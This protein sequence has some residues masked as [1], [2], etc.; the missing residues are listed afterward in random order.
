MN[1]FEMVSKFFTKPNNQSQSK[2]DRRKP[3]EDLVPFSPQASHNL[4]VSPDI[5]ST[6]QLESY[7][8]WIYVAVT[9]LA[10]SV[11]EIELKLFESKGDNEPEEVKTH[12]AIDVLQDVNQFMTFYDLVELYQ[13]YMELSGEAFWWLVKSDSGE[14]LQIYPY[15]RPDRMIVVSDSKEFIKGYVYVVPG[16][17]TEVPFSTDE[18]VHFK[19]VNPLDPYRGYST[20]KAG[21]AA[22]ATDQV[23]SIWNWKFFKNNAKPYGII[24]SEQTITDDQY[25]R[26]ITQWD[27]NHK[28]EDNNYRISVLGGA[29]KYKDAGF[30]QKD[31]DFANLKRW[32]RDE[33]LALFKVPMGVINPDETITYANADAAKKVF[34]EMVIVPKMTKFVKALNEFY[35]PQF[36]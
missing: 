17:S 6:A 10:Q 30:T 19:T 27:Q 21:E 9:K 5:G 14:V 36:E 7:R 35:L 3:K 20:V 18:I 26:I 25:E 34:Q 29:L 4:P 31:M 33:I 24:E 12:D 28:G 13:T 1:I 23:S 8:S 11:A 32:T 2:Q 15:L 22:V 16:T